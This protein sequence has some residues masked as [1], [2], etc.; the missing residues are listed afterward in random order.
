MASL[1]VEAHSLS[2]ITQLASN[3]PR[4]PRNPTAQK[5]S[6]L[7]LY[8]ARV[9]GTRDIILTTLKP[10]LKNVTAQDVASSLYYLHFNTADDLRISEEVRTSLPPDP[11][12][13]AR[14][15][16]LH[17]PL[18][19]KPLPESARASLEVSQADLASGGVNA[20]TH[21]TS[22]SPLTNI[23]T[24]HSIRRRPVGPRL[25]ISNSGATSD[26]VP[27]AE[28]EASLPSQNLGRSA[29]VSSDSSRSMELG[30]SE[31]SANYGG[32]NPIDDFSITII[33]RDPTSGAQWNIGEVSGRPAVGLKPDSGSR[34]PP[35]TKKPYFDISVDITSPGYAPFRASHTNSQPTDGTTSAKLPDKQSFIADQIK[36]DQQRGS[37]LSSSFHRQV[38]MEGSGFWARS[39]MQHKRTASDLALKSATRVQDESSTST[40]GMPEGTTRTSHTRHSSDESDE[41]GYMFTSLWGGRCKFTT[42]S[43]GRSLRC[44]HILANNTSTS[45]AYESMAAAPPPAPVSELRFNLPSSDIFASFVAHTKEQGTKHFRVPKFSHIRNKLSSE[46]SPALP[47]RPPNSSRYFTDSEDPQDRPP[48]S[49]RSNYSSFA[50]NLNGEDDDYDVRHKS[51]PGHD[52]DDGR[53]DLSLGQEKA[54]GGN[55]GKRAKLGKLVIHDEGFKMLDLVVAANMGVWWS[56]WEADFR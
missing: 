9:P 34:S 15:T 38:S 49:P 56:V 46:N 45:H 25:P 40:T 47:P 39:A 50:D 44:K 16:S 22:K 29:K 14:S 53:L 3:P 5:R 20:R 31:Q 55:R 26:S 28:D 52:E 37:T 43:G 11:A 42:G 19:R 51:H 10:Q 41:K 6:P 2:D 23:S 33:R 54:G 27:Q 30:V 1:F 21:T 24:Q 35:K 18:S 36:A 7:T 32:R 8:I 12:E 4:Y 17:K 13:L 48:L